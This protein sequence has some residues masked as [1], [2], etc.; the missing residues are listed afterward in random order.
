MSRGCI[1]IGTIAALLAMYWYWNNCCTFSDCSAGYQWCKKP[2]VLAVKKNKF[3]VNFDFD[4]EKVP[5]P[6]S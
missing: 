6:Y 4:G 5:Y 2:G 1:G 3:E